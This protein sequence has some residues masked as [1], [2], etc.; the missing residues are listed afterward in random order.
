MY[1]TPY[2]FGL[3]KLRIGSRME[4]PLDTPHN[5]VIGVTGTCCL[6]RRIVVGKVNRYFQTYS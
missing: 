5:C 1:A 2:A 6:G 3:L 4:N